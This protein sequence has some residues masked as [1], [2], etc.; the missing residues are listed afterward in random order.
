MQENINKNPLKIKTQNETR[1]GLGTEIE[2]IQFRGNF[3]VQTSK[4]QEQKPYRETKQQIDEKFQGEEKQRDLTRTQKPPDTPGGQKR[5]ILE[6]Y[7][8]MQVS[9]D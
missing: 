6:K 3:T 9:V 4:Y 5:K 7:V 8:E 2:K 1:P